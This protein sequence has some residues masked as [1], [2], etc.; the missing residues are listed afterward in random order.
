MNAAG[1]R[2]VP[3][4]AGF[5]IVSI[6]LVLWFSHLPLVDYPNH[7]ARLYI[8]YALPNN[9]YL[10]QFFIFKWIF[11]PYLGLDLLAEPFLD[12]FSAEVAGNIVVSISLIMIYSSTIFLDRQL[13]KEK[14]GLS[15]F[16]GIF[17]Y[18]GALKFGFVNYI[19]GVGFAILAFG[20]WVHNREKTGWLWLVLSCVLSGLVFVMHLYAFGIY[21]ICVAG[22]ECSVF[23]ER[24]ITERRLQLSRLR[25]PFN[26]A[27]SLVV[28]LLALQL[29]ELSANY[30][31]TE[32]GWGSLRW[33]ARALASPIVFSDYF[34]EIPLLIA[35]SIILVGALATRI[36]VVN[37]RM[38]IPLIAF[39]AIFAVMP[40]M[41]LGSAFADYRMPSGVAFFALASLRWGNTSPAR[42]NAVSS[43]LAACLAVRVAS[44]ISQWQPAQAVIEE[45]DAALKQIPPGS[46]LF[47]LLDRN[48][49]FWDDHM[50]SLLHVAVFAAT[51]RGAFVPYIFAD[52]GESPTRGVDLL[53]L[54]PAYR[55]YQNIHEIER[56]DYLLDMRKHEAAIGSAVSLKEIA[57]G[58]TFV[59]YQIR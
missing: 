4:I 13:N 10:S 25:V 41:L 43:L 55:D 46:R 15:L 32:W 59:L 36:I 57:R 31:P 28:P 12:Y 33:K 18:N 47:V 24:L 39:G 51:K 8:H 42:I 6:L 49:S 37:S 34:T 21:A 23:L 48:T 20:A 40:F 58:Q 50:S 56:Y 35:V 7:L 17:L 11:T 53:K 38:L 29:T 1:R 26:G 19:I 30:G 22:Y 16:S 54:T 52:N 14:W 2:T 5:V 45:Y 27:V 44:V 9:A 3:T